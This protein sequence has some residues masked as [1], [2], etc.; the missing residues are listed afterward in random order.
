M[1]QG[2]RAE[3]AAVLAEGEALLGLD[4]RLQA[5][6]PLPPLGD[7]A[8]ELVDELDRA[9]AHDVVDVAAQ[10]VLGVEGVAQGG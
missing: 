2:D 6:A 5:V 3:D 8:G 9:A 1:L 4:R 10:E 7:A